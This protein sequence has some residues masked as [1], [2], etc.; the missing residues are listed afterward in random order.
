MN[1]MF[2]SARTTISHPFYVDEA[3][4]PP[5][6]VEKGL[7]RGNRGGNRPPHVLNALS[8]PPRIESDL[9]ITEQLERDRDRLNEW[10][11]AQKKLGLTP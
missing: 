6:P 5:Q 9:T 1:R 2:C 7:R 4:Q 10:Y 11:K 8:Q 3:P